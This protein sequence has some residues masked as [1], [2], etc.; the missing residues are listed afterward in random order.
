VYSSG[1]LYSSH[2]WKTP[3]SDEHY[4]VFAFHKN[5]YKPD[6]ALPK[7][8]N[9]LITRILDSIR[10]EWSAEALRQQ[11]IAKEK[12]PNEVYPEQLPELEWPDEEWLAHES[13]EQREDREFIKKMKILAAKQGG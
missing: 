5:T 4:L 10:I 8:Y 2:Y 3:I 13:D 7:A 1:S 12:W 6:T 11:A 9:E